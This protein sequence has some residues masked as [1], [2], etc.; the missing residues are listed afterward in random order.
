MLL[1][2]YVNIVYELLIEIYCS[3]YVHSSVV[4]VTYN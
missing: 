1:Y 3:V 4:L 2:E